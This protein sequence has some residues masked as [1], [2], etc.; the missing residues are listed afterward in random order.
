MVVIVSSVSAHC[1]ALNTCTHTQ[2]AIL[3]GLSAFIS[4]QLKPFYAVYIAA[5]ETAVEFLEV[6]L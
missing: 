5:W 2:M 4:T 6:K 3:Q 1:T